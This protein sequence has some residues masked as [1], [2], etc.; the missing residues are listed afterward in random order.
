MLL[1]FN[2]R[3]KPMVKDGTKR[4]TIRDKRKVPGR[5]G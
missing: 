1:G 5:V 3:F 2:K 4:H